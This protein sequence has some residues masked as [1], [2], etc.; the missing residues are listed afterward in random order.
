[1]RCVSTK[2][3][4]DLAEREGLCFIETSAKDALNVEPAFAEVLT[5]I[6]R[7]FLGA[8]FVDDGKRKAAPACWGKAIDIGCIGRGKHDEMEAKKSRCCS[9]A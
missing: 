5:R 9:T 2:E 7:K 6:Y 1:M 4:R 8:K 3:G